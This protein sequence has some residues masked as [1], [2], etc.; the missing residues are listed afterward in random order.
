MYVAMLA[1]RAPEEL[2]GFG[3]ALAPK[4]DVIPEVLAALEQHREAGATVIVATASL[5]S[6][7]A[8][9]L[10][11]KGIAVD[12]VIGTQPVIE[13]GR[14]SGELARGECV[15]VNKALRLQEMLQELPGP[16]HVTAYGNLPADKPILDPADVAFHVRHAEM[17]EYPA[18]ARAS[19]Q[20]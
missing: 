7:I 17:F 2:V 10:E 8:R 12:H 14:C 18:G 11:L 1:S 15:G 19:I 9:V 3:D 13:A 20:S 6:V 16:L 5:D 4:L